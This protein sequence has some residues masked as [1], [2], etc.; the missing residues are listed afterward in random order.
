MNITNESALRSKLTLVVDET[1][2]GLKRSLE[3]SGFRVIV[4]KQGLKD[5]ELIPF[6]TGKAIVTQNSKD[7]TIDAIIHDFD[8]IGIEHIKYID[9][10]EDRTNET[11]K[12]I[13]NAVRLSKFY[14]SRGN[15]FLRVLDDGKYTLEELK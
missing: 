11:A 3:D 12:K 9:S 10:K 1:S 2:L 4:F 15:W 7:F 8:I 14:N 6:L 5:F 13:A